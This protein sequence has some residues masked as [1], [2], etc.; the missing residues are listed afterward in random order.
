ML[1]GHA[2]RRRRVRQVAPGGPERPMEGRPQGAGSGTERTV[3]FSDPLSNVLL[4]GTVRIREKFVVWEDNGD[5]G[6]RR[7]SFVTLSMTRPNL[8]TFRAVRQECRMEKTGEG[9][10]R[11]TRIFACQPGFLTR[12]VLG[13]VVHRR[14]K[15]M[16][17]TKCPALFLAAYGEK[18]GEEGVITG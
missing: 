8:F 5:D 6:V 7:F 18:K 16:I 14:F 15:H 1:A 11:L 9:I 13:P 17:E 3:V 10:C 2:R 4:V 12:Y